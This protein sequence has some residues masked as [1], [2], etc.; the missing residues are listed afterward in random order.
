MHA[1]LV[2]WRSGASGM[3]AN[4]ADKNSTFFGVLKT[5]ARPCCP[6]LWALTVAGA[7]VR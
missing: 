3:G 7:N 5:G 6:P 1:R 2:F 4:A